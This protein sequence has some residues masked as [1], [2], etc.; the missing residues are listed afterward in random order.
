MLGVF[1]FNAYFDFLGLTG[2]DV[3]TG[4]GSSN[5][6]TLPLDVNDV[7]SKYLVL[8]FGR[9]QF[10]QTFKS[11]KRTRQTPNER[12]KLPGTALERSVAKRDIGG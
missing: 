2:V 10:R 6:L 1:F 5:T 7:Q 11:M 8:K 12:I 9:P 4:S 3:K